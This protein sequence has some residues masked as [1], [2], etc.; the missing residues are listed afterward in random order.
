MREL[1]YVEG[2][3]FVIEARFADNRMERLPALAAELV[4]LK[5]DVIVTDSTPGALAT[6]RATSSIPI[7]AMDI[8]DPVGSGLAASLARPG[9]NVTG[10]SLMALEIRTKQ[11][12][13]LRILVPTLSHVAFLMNFDNAAQVRTY[14]EFAARAG[15]VGV[16]TFPVNGRTAKEIEAGISAAAGKERAQALMTAF[17]ATFFG[18][19]RQQI[20]DLANRRKLPAIYPY[21]EFVEASG[22]M[23]Y[24]QDITESYRDAAVYV[25]KILRGA[26]PGELP[27][28]Q[29]TRFYLAINRKTAKALGLAIPAELLLR[30]DKV[31]E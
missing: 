8:G 6:K 4:Q 16:K 31:I 22:L 17:D 21:R 26:N 7:V 20:V 10:R 15:K 25:D 18:V 13:L 19:H 3:D 2:R 5:V 9:G 29:P 28:Q 12:E 1:G 30:A 11:L 23:S 27:F 24:G 14:D